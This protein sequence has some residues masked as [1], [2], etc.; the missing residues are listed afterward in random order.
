MWAPVWAFGQASSVK[1]SHCVRPP[2]PEGID[3]PLPLANHQWPSGLSEKRQQ[4]WDNGVWKDLDRLVYTYNDFGNLTG[5]TQ[6]F[7]RNGVWENAGWLVCTYDDSQ[8]L[9]YRTFRDW[10]NQE[11]VESNRS[12]LAHDGFGRLTE[13]VSQSRGASTGG[14]WINYGRELYTYDEFGNLVGFLEQDWAETDWVDAERGSATYD[15]SGNLLEVLY[16]GWDGGQWLVS[17]RDRYTYDQNGFLTGSILQLWTGSEWLDSRR[18]FYT[19][20]DNGDLTEFMDQLWTGSEWENYDRIYYARDDAGN[21]TQ[22]VFERWDSSI[23]EQRRRILRS[24][25]ASGN[26]IE[27]ADQT[28]A[29]TAEWLN[30]RRTLLSYQS[31]AAPFK[32]VLN[33]P[34]D[35]ATGIPPLPTL[36]WQTQEDVEAYH[37]KIAADTSFSTPIVESDNMAVAAITLSDPLSYSTTYYWRVRAGRDDGSGK[38]TGLVFGPWSETRSFTTAVGTE[39]EGVASLPT[40]FALHPPYPNPFNPSTTIGF[41]LPQ[42]EDVRV[43]IYD[44]LGRL[45]E[46]LVP[47]GVGAG[48]GQLA[49]G[50]HRVTWDAEDVPSG[51]YFVRMEA[52]A[53]SSTQRVLLLR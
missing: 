53:Y 4:T 17:L 19:H 33:S 11:W 34:E 27:E 12:V 32:V 52:G 3:L 41:D 30:Q 39:T 1:L 2:A 46:S 40:E 42:A 8:N 35:G 18:A 51:V 31:I 43:T 28:W 22:L 6:Q 5:R 48:S 49:A 38:T 13:E 14:E 44:A 37:L 47:D 21:L 24:Y 16:E 50:R 9:A 15:E 10:R 26:L 45:V 36:S 25:D 20:E 23:W 29:D 7:W